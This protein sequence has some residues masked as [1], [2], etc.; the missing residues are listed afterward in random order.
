MLKF[1]YKGWFLTIK[2]AYEIFLYWKSKQWTH[3]LVPFLYIGLFIFWKTLNSQFLVVSQSS[4]SKLS[5]AW[6]WQIL[7]V[8]GKICYIGSGW[9]HAWSKAKILKT[10]WLI[11]H[12]SKYYMECLVGKLPSISTTSKSFK[13]SANTLYSQQPA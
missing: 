3:V 4:S 2:K 5:S 8:F 1:P 12:E 11:N 9:E 10:L 7:E 13:K 6:F